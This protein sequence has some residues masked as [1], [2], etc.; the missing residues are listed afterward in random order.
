MF[1][2]LPRRL[3]GFHGDDRQASS[4]GSK[5]QPWKHAH[6]EIPVIAKAEK[7]LPHYLQTN[8]SAEGK[9]NKGAMVTSPMTPVLN[10]KDEE[11]CLLP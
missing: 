1:L 3:C 9:W 11:M 6:Q 10:H 5:S 4:T 7:A 8:F 2:L